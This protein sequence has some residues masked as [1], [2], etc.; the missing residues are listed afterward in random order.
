[1]RPREFHKRQ[2]GDFVIV[3]GAGI[4]LEEPSG[5][6]AAQAIS[7]ALL[8]W[9]A[10][11]ARERSELRQRMTPG[12]RF[13]PYQFLRFEGLIQA[14][15]EIDPNILYFLESTQ[16]FGNPNINHGL[17]ATM[18]VEGSIVIT[19]NFDT[20]IEQAAGDRY[21]S[22]FVLSSNR[23]TPQ[24]DDRL[25]KIHG[26]FPWRRGRNV[27]PRATLTQIGKLG[28]GFERFSAFQDWIRS[29]T[30]GK[31]LI[32]IGYSASDSFDVVPLIENC[33]NATTVTWFNYR[34]TAGSV[35]ETKVRSQKGFA[36]FPCKRNTAFA[37]HALTNLASRPGSPCEVRLVNGKQIQMFMA[38][39]VQLP[40][41]EA[42]VTTTDCGGVGLKNLN[43]LQRTLSENPL[44]VHQQRVIRRIVDDGMFGEAY[45]SEYE[46]KPAR[47]NHNVLGNSAKFPRRSVEQQAQIAFERGNP[48]R[49]FRIL[50]KSARKSA[51]R[52]QILLLLHHFEFG[53]GEENKDLHRLEQAIRKSQRVVL[54]SGALWGLIMV[55]WMK[56]FR[57]DAEWR[58]VFDPGKRKELSEIVIKHSLRVVY[59][60][61]RAGLQTWFSTAARLAAKHLAVLGSFDKAASLITNLLT[62]IDQE[63]SVGIE[64]VAGT[65][66]ALNTLGIQSG[67]PGLLKI[68]S[69]ILS[70]L[71]TKKS[72]VVGLLRI[73][74]QAERAHAR[75][76]KGRVERLQEFANAHILKVD[77]ADRWDIRAVFNY[78]RQS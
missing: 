41:K 16:T 14:I 75:G 64:E 45:A 76:Q 72:P 52:D 49:A 67:R 25:I 60:G 53:V 71:D 55:E 3:A 23:Q 57:L 29:A 66:C 65:A 12:N 69:R 74:A 13:N 7:E 28:L 20:R 58:M 9:I 44:T 6:P 62:W 61:L 51:D 34:P 54:R 59:Y 46:T 17:L 10:R 22:T 4:S 68:A 39:L 19:T 42:L 38:T 2:P 32:V 11:N 47:E 56:A 37:V 15:A 30:T 18:A 27:T 5:I 31:H 40:E 43:A 24:P 26:S 77:P 36:P 48:D 1:V 35:H 8:K 78:L 70:K 63:T 50:E 73:A 21:L 33:S